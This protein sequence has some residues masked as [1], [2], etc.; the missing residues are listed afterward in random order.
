MLLRVS[1]SPAHSE[2]RL[3]SPR[4]AGVVSCCRAGCGTTRR[5]A[6]RAS[7]AASGTL[8]VSTSAMNHDLICE[9]SPCVRGRA[10]SQAFQPISP[11]PCKS[12][13]FQSAK[14]R[15]F[16]PTPEFFTGDWVAVHKPA[17]A[18]Y[19]S[20]TSRVQVRTFIPTRWRTVPQLSPFNA[21]SATCTPI[22]DLRSAQ[23]PTP[24]G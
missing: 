12:D 17:D 15:A 1:R 4:S 19:D 8:I 6:E 24:R 3:Y 21:H 2:T 22:T 23:V 5:C 11:E 14:T 16:L 18:R 20:G 9:E 13:Y 7:S 10:Q